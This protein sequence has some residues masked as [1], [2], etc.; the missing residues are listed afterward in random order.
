LQITA[1]NME[2]RNTK[3]QLETIVEKLHDVLNNLEHVPGVQAT[4]LGGGADEEDATTT[5][6][7]A[8]VDMDTR[9]E[10]AATE[11]RKQHAGEFLP[12]EGERRG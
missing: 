3:K 4:S 8:N 2:N 11:S 12:A 9:G 5:S 1:S 6:A 7:L 10:G